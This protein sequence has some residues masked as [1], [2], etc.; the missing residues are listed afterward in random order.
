MS[1]ES[2]IA[3]V[4]TVQ[5]EINQKL[6]TSEITLTLQNNWV[7]YN[8]GWQ[9]LRCT[10]NNL[11]NEVWIRGLIKGGSNTENTAITTL[12]SGWRPSQNNIYSCACSGGFVRIDMKGYGA[13]TTRVTDSHP[14]SPSGWLSID[15][16][17]L[18]E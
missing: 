11:T 10:K 1:L 5:N 2:C 9:T 15:V 13:L 14:G 18:A 7:N 12:P 4:Q 6:T 3:N 16:R 17:F 8:G